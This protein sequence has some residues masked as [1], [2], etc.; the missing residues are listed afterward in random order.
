MLCEINVSVS[1]IESDQTLQGN[2]ALRSTL[3]DMIKYMWFALWIDAGAP[4]PADPM[5]YTGLPPSSPALDKLI[6][7]K[8]IAH[9]EADRT[10]L[11][12]RCVSDWCEGLLCPLPNPNDEFITPGGFEGEVYLC[13]ISMRNESSFVNVVW[14]FVI[15]S[16]SFLHA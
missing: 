2:G 8:T 7:A 13:R 3:N 10:D 5:L 15:T 6:T 1:S 12:C 11:A 4:T 14:L 16:F 9:S